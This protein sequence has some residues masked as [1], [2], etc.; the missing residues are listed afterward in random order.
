MAVSHKGKRKIIYKD[1]L[2]LWYIIPDDDYDFLFYLKIIS[3]DQTLYL[4]YET[5]Q[6]NNL[7][8]QPKIGIVKSEKLKSGRYKFS[9][10]IQ[11]KIFS[12]YNVRLILDWHD[13]QDGS[14]I[15]EVFK[16]PKNP[17]EHIDFKSGTIVYIVKDFSRSN[18]KSDM[19]KVSYSQNY[20][21]IAGW[22]GSERGYHITIIKNND[23]K[24]PVAETHQSFFELEEAITSAVTM[25]EN[26]INEKG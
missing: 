10:R 16:M 23:D 11:D 17:F 4:S 14:A 1:K 18:L 26:W 9:P 15:P 19:L 12:N 24:N 21:L 20:L 8:I 13:S 25:I 2:Y 3:D 6:A 5:D 7:F 22:H